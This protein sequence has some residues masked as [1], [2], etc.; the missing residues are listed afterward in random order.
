MARVDGIKKKLE[1]ND[2]DEKIIKEIIDNGDLVDV[3]TRMEKI[4]SPELIYEILDSS[5]CGTS[6]KELKALK[7]IDVETLQDRINNISSL[8][9]FHS[10]WNVSLNQDNTITAGWIIKKDDKYA[11]V[12]SAIVKKEVKVSDLSITNRTMPL[13]YC[14]CCAGHC[15]RHLEKLLDIQLKTKEIVSSPIN[16]NGQKPCEFIFEINSRTV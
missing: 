1:R 2:I 4:L 15:R 6:I 13:T 5:A 12:C 8:N 7:K 9:D 3:I 11:C 16:S 14:L 10:D